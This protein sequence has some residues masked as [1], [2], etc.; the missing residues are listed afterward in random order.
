MAVIFSIGL[1]IYFGI[2]LRGSSG[3]DRVLAKLLWGIYFLLGLS[4][5]FI[6]VTGVLE[7]AYP[8][9]Y[10]ALF[11]IFSGVVLSI[12]GFK[13]F[14]SQSVHDLHHSIRYQNIIENFLIILQLYAIIFF[15]PFALDSFVGS[16]GENRLMLAQ[17]MDEMASY[18]LFNTRA[19]L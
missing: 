10:L 13:K 2:F 6:A 1:L 9:N 11:V 14:K 5:T 3:R 19:G 7:S 8:S 12:Y 17:K 15:L 4:G 16:P 18:G